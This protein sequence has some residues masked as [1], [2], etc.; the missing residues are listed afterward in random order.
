MVQSNDT[1]LWFIYKVGPFFGE[2]N[3]WVISSMRVFV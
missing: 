3:R 2:F 1:P